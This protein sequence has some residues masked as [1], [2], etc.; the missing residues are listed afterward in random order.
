MQ[1][2]NRNWLPDY[3][4]PRSLLPSVQETIIL[5][6]QRPYLFQDFVGKAITFLESDIVR[7]TGFV[8]DPKTALPCK[9]KC[10]DESVFGVDLCLYAY[11]GHY[12]FDKG[13]LGGRFNASSLPAAVHHSK[14]N[15]D[16][17]GAHV[18]YC[19]DGDRFGGIARPMHESETSADC[20]YLMGV[21]DPFR[22]V[23]DDARKNIFLYSPD[24]WQVL[25]SIPNEYLQP[26]WSSHHIKLLVDVESLIVDPVP[27]DVNKPFTHKIAGRSLFHVSPRFL[28]R[29]PEGSAGRFT[30]SEKTPIGDELVAEYFHIYDSKAD[31]VD[32]SPV[33][34]FLPYMK[35]ILSSKVAPYPLKAAVTHSNIEH[36]RLVDCVRAERCRPA[37]FASFSGV[38]IDLYDPQVGAY[39]NLFQPI[40]VAIK[41]AGKAREVEF[42]SAEVHQIFDRLE[43]AEPLLPLGGV[44]GYPRPDHVLENFKYPTVGE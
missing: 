38:F 35:Y 23:Y 14:C 4:H 42:T 20:G 13:R 44:L 18:G 8:Y 12:P 24:N 21:I 40:G 6:Q 3:C 39:V 33:H 1:Q 27:Y 16:F 22:E 7:E 29:L 9:W 28:E 34:R 26:S 5:F 32:G 2:T 43:P 37:A 31:L 41:A 30:S 11:T 25:I 10:A 15:I 17:G 19:C 36:N